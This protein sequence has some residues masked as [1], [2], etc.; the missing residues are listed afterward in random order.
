MLI[1]KGCSSE[2]RQIENELL[3]YHRLVLVHKSLF[4]RFFVFVLSFGGFI[5][6]FFFKYAHDY[7]IREGGVY[8]YRDPLFHA[9]L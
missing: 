1:R 9:T 4:L 6:I 7:S 2:T 8:L 5:S 3:L